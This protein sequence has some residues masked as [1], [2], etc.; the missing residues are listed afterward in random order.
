MKLLIEICYLRI[1]WLFICNYLFVDGQSLSKIAIRKLNNSESIFVEVS[2]G[3]Q[4]IFHGVNAI[5]K[6]IPYIPVTE[7]WDIDISLSDKDHAMLQSLGVNV[8]RLGS[9]WKG[10]EPTAGDY[11]MTYIS[12]LRKILKS[13]ESYGIYTLFDMH[14]DVL[15][16]Y[17]CGE[18]IPDFAVLKNPDL[19]LSQ[20]FPSPVDEPFTAVASDGFPT[21]QDCNRNGWP[22]YYN[23]HECGYAFEQ[24][25]LNNASLLPWANFWGKLAIEFGNE[26][27][28]LGYELINEP[29]AGDVLAEPRLI[30]PSVADRIR[31][32][33]AY[34]VIARTI[35][36][37]D[38]ST[39]I[40]FAAVTWDD[41]VPVGFDHAPGGDE[42]APTSVFAFHFYEA[43]QFDTE[44]YFRTRSEDAA[45]LGTGIML[46]EFERANN[47]DDDIN[48]ADDLFERVCDACDN[49][50]IS[51][52]S[53]EY[54][55]FCKETPESLA[56]SSQQA[57]FG[58]CKTGYGGHI[59]IWNEDGTPH[60]PTARR[61]ARTYAQKIQGTAISMR[62]DITTGDFEFVWRVDTNIKEA[63]EIFAHMEYHY[64]LGITVDTLPPG[65]VTWKM[66]STNVISVSATRLAD[67]GE[68]LRLTIKKVGIPSFEPTDR[69][70]RQPIA[71][72]TDYPSARPSDAGSLLY[73]G[74]SQ[75][76]VSNIGE[77]DFAANKNQYE[78]V[79]KQSIIA[80]VSTSK[81][82]WISMDSIDSFSST[83]MTSQISSNQLSTSSSSSLLLSYSIKTNTNVVS[84]S[85]I[86]QLSNNNLLTTNI[87]SLA[88]S[89]GCQGLQEAVVEGNVQVVDLTD[90]SNPSDSSTSSSKSTSSIS[91]STITIILVVVLVIVAILVSTYIFYSCKR[92]KKP[93]LNDKA[94]SL[95]K[96]LIGD[97]NLKI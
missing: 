9:Q 15:S 20:A 39:L 84:V 38:K 6:G 45:R 72:P 63:T 8:Y 74:I 43:P 87:N 16:E 23:T 68:I 44:T 75:Q 69:P 51:W 93:L 21:R 91:K 37:I 47:A 42:N 36:A 97:Y 5:V 62:F 18:G 34:D 80:T 61:I 31:L 24:L 1:V 33:P 22:S 26:N 17:F 94:E 30:I 10:V 76:Y 54:K 56:G 78:T 59:W 46:T 73:Y 58:S 3:R 52:A 2:T 25:Y 81:E 27:A 92:K 64:P 41:I 65:K 19:Q 12:K 4:V 35:R 89:N 95:S 55:T 71:S 32:Q 85:D 11:N 7:Y 96:S 29:W 90:V 66:S 70:T 57:A 28:L 82:S 79:I 14:Q 60:V 88:M 40:F 67:D 77:V 53:W 48:A 49:R 13:A 50:R 83:L 86:N